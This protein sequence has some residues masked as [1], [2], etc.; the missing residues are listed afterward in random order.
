M[1]GEFVDVG[2]TRLYY[3]ATGTRG[4]GD[5]VV[6]LHGFPGSS[7]AWRAVA[8]LLPEGR[9][10]VVVDLMG[11]GRSDGPRGTRSGLVD[12]AAL[13]RGLMDDLALPRATIIGHGLG[14]AIA[15]RL[16][17]DAPARVSALGLVSPPAFDAWPARLG[18]LARAVRPLAPLL[19]A[20]VLASFVHGSAIAGYA[21]ADEGR[22][23]LDLALRAYPARLG[24]AAI[25]AHLAALRDPAIAGM[26]AD[27]GRIAIPVAIVWG[28]DDPFLPPALGAR[29]RDAIPGAALT[30]IP[31]A[32]HF[33]PEDAPDRCARALAGLLARA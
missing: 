28:E 32:R 10:A 16:A 33:V 15:L 18:R 29:L 9:R 14:G 20:A 1:R 22:R 8:P 2:G 25:L 4:G 11:C 13:I 19:G 30:V 7:H 3:Y 24:T 26:A 17:L 27:L 12:H 21:D 23:A 6:L 31:G 5:P